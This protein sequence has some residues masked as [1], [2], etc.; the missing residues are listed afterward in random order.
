MFS[1]LRESILG[2]ADAAGIIS[3]NIINIRDFSADRHNKTDDYPFGGGQ[4]M[5]LMPQP[6]F[7]ALKAAGAEGTRNIYLSPRG[8]MLGMKLAAELASED[9]ITLFCG[10]YEGLD[11]R[12]IDEWNMEE[13]SIGDYILTG[14]E[15]AAMV[16]IDVVA[17]MI[18]GVLSVRTTIPTL[19]RTQSRSNRGAPAQSE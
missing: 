6:A 14:G 18:P 9:E 5:V 2:R 15:L 19:K 16:L 3:F 13:V 1:S 17:R 4:G 10:H 12:V 11:Q 7:D 8:K